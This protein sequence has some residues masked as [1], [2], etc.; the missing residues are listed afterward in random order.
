MKF[1]H[2]ADLH[3]GSSFESASFDKDI[4]KIR[5]EELFTS[6][7]DMIQNCKKL[8]ID[9]LLIAGD[10][11]EEPLIKASDVKRVIDAFEKIKGIKVV[12]CA[13]NHDY[14]N[15]KSYYNLIDFPDNVTIFNKEGLNSIYFDD[16]NTWVYGFSFFKNNYDA[17]FT[18]LPKLDKS[19]NNILLLHC[20]V[21]TAKSKYLPIKKEKLVNSDFDY[22][23]L[24]H[25]HK[26]LRVSEKIFYSGSL[27]PLDFSERGVH[28]YVYGTIGRVK[29]ENVLIKGAKR[30]FKLVKVDIT[31]LSSLEQICDLIESQFADGKMVNLFRVV[32]E[33]VKHNLININDIENKL[34]D[35]FFY[36]E[37]KDNTV[38]D[39]DLEALRRDNENNVIGLYIENFL[40]SKDKI[41]RKALYYGLD[42]LLGDERGNGR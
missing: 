30:E 26:S 34:I 19:K 35:K 10:L 15:D 16:I 4:A 32:L 38:K 42:A 3:L 24:G 31:G 1:I 22:I 39:Y 41:D 33:G 21:L 20:D 27:E 9:L 17:D 2:T 25:I 7:E 14:I 6:F 29:D 12:I 13:G 18:V 36:I 11:F 28:G 5:R 23:A 37:F 40:G 8:E